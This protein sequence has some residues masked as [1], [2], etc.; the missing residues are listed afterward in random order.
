MTA[1]QIANS[2]SDERELEMKTTKKG[3]DIPR[4]NY[5]GQSGLEGYGCKLM[6]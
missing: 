6:P 1:F 4:E 5:L 3:M 2:L